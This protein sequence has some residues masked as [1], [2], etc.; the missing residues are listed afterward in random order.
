MNSVFWSPG[1]TLDDVIGEVCIAALRHFSYSREKAAKSL[2][3]SLK[4]YN[5]YLDASGF[6]SQL[7]AEKKEVLQEREDAKLKLAKRKTLYS[8]DEHL[9]EIK[10]EEAASEAFDMPV[11]MRDRKLKLSPRDHSDAKA[12]EI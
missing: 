12:A 1:A 10:R 3:I 6:R 8:N 9:P 4:T 11:P 7:L 5:R 2:G